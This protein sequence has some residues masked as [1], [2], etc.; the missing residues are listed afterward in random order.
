VVVIY[1]DQA[2]LKK[3]MDEASAL[4]GKLDNE[5]TEATK[6]GGKENDAKK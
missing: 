3:L 1:E 4:T 6:P 5:L 2:G